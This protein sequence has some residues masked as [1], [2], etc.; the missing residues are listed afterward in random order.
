[1][2]RSDNPHVDTC[3]L[4]ADTHVDTYTSVSF[5]YRY[6]YLIYIHICIH[7]HI[8]MQRYTYLHMYIYMYKYRELQIKSSK[9]SKIAQKGPK[10]SKMFQNGIPTLAHVL[11]QGEVEPK[12]QKQLED[13]PKRF[14]P[15]RK[16]RVWIAYIYI[17][18]Y[19]YICIDACRYTYIHMDI[20]M[21]VY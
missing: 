9:W 20:Y 3:R 2:A 16:L 1:M 6:M 4:S 13:S 5:V 19:I 17:H 15:V 11:G 21:L 18:I 8:P 10:R 14:Y 12:G 7:T